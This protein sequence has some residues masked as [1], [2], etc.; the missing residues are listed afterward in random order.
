MVTID[1]ELDERTIDVDLSRADPDV[2]RLLE[3]SVLDGR[4]GTD[5]VVEAGIRPTRRAC[6]LN[7]AASLRVTP[8]KTGP[9]LDQVERLFLGRDDRTYARVTPRFYERVR[10]LS[11]SPDRPVYAEGHPHA[12]I[13]EELLAAL[14]AFEPD[15]AQRFDRS[16][17]WS[18]RAEGS[19]S[20]QMVIARPSAPYPAE[21]ADLDL[22]LGNPLQDAVGLVVHLGE[23][24]DGKPTNHLDLWRKLR[25][26]TRMAP[27]LCY[28]VEAAPR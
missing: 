17:L 19:P 24:L 26:Q 12:T 3:A 7:L 9:L 28:T 4:A 15:A 1:L 25:T 2:L 6:A 10:A 23:L 27:Y 13:H 5:W 11:E 21:F 16:G 18:F 8:T 14:G 20:L 22:D